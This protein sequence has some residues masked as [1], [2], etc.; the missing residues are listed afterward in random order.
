MD[1]AVTSHR[2]RPVRRAFGV[3][4]AVVAAAD[5]TVATAV[6]QNGAGIPTVPDASRPLMIAYGMVLLAVGLCAIATSFGSTAAAAPRPSAARRR[7]LEERKVVHALRSRG[8]YVAD[9]VTFPHADVDH[10]AIGPAGVLA[11]QT[12]WTNR[13]DDRGKPAVRA[14]IAAAQLRKALAVREL[15]VEIV[16]AVLTFGPGLT[17]EPGGVKVVDAVAMLNGYQADEWLEQLT[18]RVLLP[19]AVVDAVRETVADLREGTPARSS[20]PAVTDREPALVG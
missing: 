4:A 7:Q 9:D 12:R 19:D 14:R 10:V 20:S 3:L 18:S 8:W 1:M 2:A 11:I 13:P 6:E 17:E 5:L 16:P 15:D